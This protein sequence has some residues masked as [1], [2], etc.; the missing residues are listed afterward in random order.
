R[1]GSRAGERTPRG[2]APGHALR[3]HV[4]R[5]ERLAG[6]HEEP[7]ALDPAEAEVGAALRE[8]DAADELAR[9]VEDRHAIEAL[10]AAPPAPEVAVDITAHAVWNAVAGVDEEPIVREF[11]PAVHDVED[12]NL[13][14]HGAADD[15]G[16]LRLVGREARRVGPLVL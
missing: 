5:V 11:R 10:A 6:R 13:A 7:V 3:V 2:S 14:R 16:H 4:E 1:R 12:A 8:Q 15:D 9:G